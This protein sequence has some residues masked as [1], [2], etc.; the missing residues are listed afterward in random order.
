MMPPL[1]RLLSLRYLLQRWDRAA[2]ILASIA[3]GVATFVSARILNRCFEAAA[4]DTTTPL[5]GAD[6]YVT[7]GEAGVPRSLADDVRAARIPG[8]ESVQPLVFDRVVLPG[9]D[10]RVAVLLGVEASARM[11]QREDGRK[12]EVKWVGFR[13]QVRLDE[14]KVTATWSGEGPAAA[15][16]GIMKAAEAKRWDDLRGLYDRIPDRLVV[17]SRTV[18]E[19]RQRR[20]GAGQ[21]LVLRHGTRLVE[22]LVVGVLDLDDDSPLAALGRNFIGMEVGQAARVVRPSATALTAAPRGPRPRPPGTRSSRPRSTAST[23]S[24]S[25][26]RTA[27]RWPPPWPASSGERRW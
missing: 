18:F 4:S 17:V 25:R 16:A 22:C 8:L 23:C 15:L 19:E 21:P 11:F 10:G 1:Y 3:L 20:G 24:W 5:R 13:P 27:T 14:L 2:L 7:N 12:P 9:L 6:L 26:R